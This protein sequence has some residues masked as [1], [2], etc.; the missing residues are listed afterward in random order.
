MTSGAPAAGKPLVI[1]LAEDSDADAKIALR[2]FNAASR[3][4]VI[5]VTHDGQEALDYL[6]GRGMYVDRAAYAKP[7]LL[8]LDLNMPRVDGFAVIDAL[9]K[10]PAMREIPIVIMTTSRNAGDV[11]RAYQAGAASYIPKPADYVEFARSVDQF[12]VYWNDVSLLPGRVE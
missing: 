9:K 3:P 4:S 1:L 8:L 2:A 11:L 10:D 5:H 12:C 6:Y 7:D